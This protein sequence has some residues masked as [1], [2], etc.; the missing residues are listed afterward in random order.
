M[1]T[2]PAKTIKLNLEGI[3]NEELCK[4]ATPADFIRLGLKRYDDIDRNPWGTGWEMKTEHFHLDIDCTFVVKLAR[5][6][7][8]TD[9]ITLVVHN[10]SELEAV[11]DWIA[12]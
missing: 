6:N 11:I 2:Q 5:R 4:K 10:L 9:Y 12:E 3:V 8:D 1:A 7:P